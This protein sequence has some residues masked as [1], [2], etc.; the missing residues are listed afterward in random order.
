[1]CD[2][3]AP[4]LK[5]ESYF[6]VPMVV[7]VKCAMFGPDILLSVTTWTFVDE[8]KEMIQH[9]E[10]TPTDD[11]TLNFAGKTLEDGNQLFIYGLQNEST[12]HLTVGGDGGGHRW[13]RRMGEPALL[14]VVGCG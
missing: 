5:G 12:I 13:C 1:M 4:F 11:Q 2:V 7:F 10:G 6:E 9:K 14:G 3:V 8:V